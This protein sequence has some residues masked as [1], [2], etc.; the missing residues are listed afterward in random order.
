MSALSLLTLSIILPQP[1]PY[2]KHSGAF[3]MLEMPGKWSVDKNLPKFHE[4]YL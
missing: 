4:K 2:V 1:A 3:F